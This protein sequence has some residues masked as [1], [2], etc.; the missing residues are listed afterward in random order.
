MSTGPGFPLR[1]ESV[2]QPPL[3]RVCGTQT[4]AG[5]MWPIPSES[6][7]PCGTQALPPWEHSPRT[8]SVAEA[9]T[10]P[11]RFSA[12]QVQVPSS[13]LMAFLM[14]RVQSSLMS[15]LCH[16]KTMKTLFVGNRNGQKL[17]P[18]KC[19]SESILEP[20]LEDKLLSSIR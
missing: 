2:Q 10:F 4:M 1:C 19:Q 12:M 20:S 6:N 18:G 17:S 15:Y 8:V 13:V 7:Y 11:T 14:R 3:Q 9:S 5:K 16:S